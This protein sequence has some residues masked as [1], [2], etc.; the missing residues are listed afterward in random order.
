[1]KRKLSIIVLTVIA[2][3]VLT[4]PH[5]VKADDEKRV[6]TSNT[7]NTDVS[8][9]V[10]GINEKVLIHLTNFKPGWY[11]IQIWFDD[12]VVYTSR[13]QVPE[14]G[15]GLLEY[16]PTVVGE[17]EIR[18]PSEE[19]PD[20]PEAEHKFWWGRFSVISETSLGSLGASTALFSGLG[21]VILRKKRTKSS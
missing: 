10:F 13:V 21:L 5:L 1:M 8:K 14:E 6:W 15:D 7:T 17:Y 4:M 12:S 11:T 19:N 2:M 9:D 16:V 3:L 18:I 20:R